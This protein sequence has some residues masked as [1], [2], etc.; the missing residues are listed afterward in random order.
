ML[1]L[2]KHEL[3]FLRRNCNGQCLD[4]LGDSAQA[5]DCYAYLCFGCTISGY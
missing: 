2:E 3:G 1:R 5:G 4:S